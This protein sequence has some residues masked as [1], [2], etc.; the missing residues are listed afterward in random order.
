MRIAVIAPSIYMSEKTYPQ[1]IFAP[2]VVTL[3]LVDG[4]VKKGH[5]VTLFSAPD[6][7]TKAK[8]VPGAESLLKGDLLRDKYLKREI[9]EEYRLQSAIESQN[10][11]SLDLIGRAFKE[12]QKSSF[13]IIQTDDPLV[14]A[15][16]SL[17][18]TP[19]VFT[20][21][22]PPPSEKSLD[23]WFLNRYKK[24]N[25]ISISLA[26]QKGSLSLNF[27]GNVYHG[28]KI[29]E[30]DVSYKEGQYFAY[31]GRLLVQKG[32]DIAI[33]VIKSLN[34]KLFIAT[35][36]THFNTIF[37]KEKI[38][39]YVDGRKIK[40]MGFLSSLSEKVDFLK[41][42]KAF[43][44]PIQWEEPFGLVMIESMACGTPVVAFARGSVPEVI[45]DGE[46][47]FIVNSSKEDKRGDWIV[48]KT[49]TEGFYEAVK[50]IYAM[51]KE[52]YLQMR[53]NCRKHAQENFTIEKM[54]DNYE[55]VYQ[56]ILA[57][58]G[59]ALRS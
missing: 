38:L 11:Y 24:H 47:G 14:H 46:T 21:H 50:K 17:I 48:K 27:V 43:L 16:V 34:E 2:R 33:Q 5:E 49:G 23:C 15:F 30:L 4:L 25:F 44:F 3:Q 54:V 37:V 31:M 56:K 13:D 28:I 55:K 32:A 10:L 53:Q 57:S 1:R 9:L 12:T 41:K 52:E 19:V 8:L 18:K 45:K 36:K 40:I 6:I 22:D 29:N 20:F 7:E 39:P 35:D 58:Q 59:V 42:A 51:P 26:Q